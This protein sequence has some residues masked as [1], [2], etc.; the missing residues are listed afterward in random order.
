M[1]VADG[2]MMKVQQPTR[3]LQVTIYTPRKPD[4]INLSFARIVGADEGLG[5]GTKM[6]R[7][8]LDIDAT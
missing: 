1:M 5:L 6:L 2:R 4:V 7:E 8:T 3:L